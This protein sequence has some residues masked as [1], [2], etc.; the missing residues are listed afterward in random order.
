LTRVKILKTTTVYP[1]GVRPQIYEAGRELA[2]TSI[3][4][5]QLIEHGAVEIVENK[6][7]QAAPEAKPVRGRKRAE[8]V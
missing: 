5:A 8:Q 1:D 7:I 3:A 4:L 2:V 6:A